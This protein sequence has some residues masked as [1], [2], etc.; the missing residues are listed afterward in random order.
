MSII[1]INIFMPNVEC[2]KPLLHILLC[3]VI[4]AKANS[5]A[6]L[7]FDPVIVKLVYVCMYFWERRRIY[8]SHVLKVQKKLGCYDPSFIS[9][10]GWSTV[11]ICGLMWSSHTF[12][13]TTMYYASIIL[14]MWRRHLILNKN[15]IDLTILKS[16]R[17][18]LIFFYFYML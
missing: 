3:S 2:L 11:C 1:V 8:D 12:S 15:C 17:I 9:H 16:M 13:L 4:S 18:C 14:I 5:I 6:A 10:I 7:I